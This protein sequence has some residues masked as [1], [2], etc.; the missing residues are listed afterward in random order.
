MVEVK[1]KLK[2]GGAFISPSPIARFTSTDANQSGYDGKCIANVN[3]SASADSCITC[4][5]S[6]QRIVV[7]LQTVVSEGKP[8]TRISRMTLR[9][10]SNKR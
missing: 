2:A 4:L 1:E 10:K 8:T 5:N 6:S 7:A 9:L 3:V